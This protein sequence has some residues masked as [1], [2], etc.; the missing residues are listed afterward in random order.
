MPLCSAAA[1]A[2]HFSSSRFQQV[3]LVRLRL[4]PGS[5]AV[6]HVMMVSLWTD[7]LREG[8]LDRLFLS[9]MCHYRLPGSNSG[10]IVHRRLQPDKHKN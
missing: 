4:C 9:E 1:K 6:A 5:E 8:K 2:A 3:S 7:M 10:S